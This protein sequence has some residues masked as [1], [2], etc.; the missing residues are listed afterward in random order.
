ML[1]LGR[2]SSWRRGRVFRGMVRKG[3]SWD[4]EPLMARAS[5]RG[6]LAFD[7]EVVFVNRMIEHLMMRRCS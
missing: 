4:G 1:C 3:F 7:S 5:F 2:V 6:W